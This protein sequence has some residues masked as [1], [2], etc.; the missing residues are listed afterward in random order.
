MKTIINQ[1][2]YGL[3]LVM[4]SVLTGGNMA[5]G[6]DLTVG[7]QTITLG[8]TNTFEIP[9][10][11]DVKGDKVAALQFDMNYDQAQLVFENVVAGQALIAAEKGIAFNEVSP[12]K[13]R[14]IGYGLNQNPIEN[15]E[16]IKCQFK[17][18]SGSS[19]GISPL[20]LTD[21]VLSDPDA[22]IVPSNVTDGKVTINVIDLQRAINVVLNIETDP[23]V[24]IQAD[25]NIDGVVNALD[26]QLIINITLKE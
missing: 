7:E 22:N 1:V 21:V 15:G 11:I 10:M 23:A 20:S 25:I 9:V 8:D 14:I 18:A 2:G 17:L 12:G 13:I 24:V 5:R 26:L 19:I 16:L 3:L 4:L 6:A